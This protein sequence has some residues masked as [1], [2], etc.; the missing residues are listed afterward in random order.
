MS[1]YVLATDPSDAERI[2][3]GLLWDYHGAFTVA[4]LEAAGVGA[5]W[6]CLEVG[7]GGGQLTGWLA[8]RVQPGGRVVAIDLETALLEPLRGEVVEVRRG[9]FMGEAVETAAFDLVLAQM[10]LLHLPDPAAGAR[11]LVEAAKPGGTVVIHDTDFEPVGLRDPTELEREGVAVMAGTMRAAGID[12][13]LGPKLDRVLADAGAEVERFGS[14]PAT[15]A[16]SRTAAE[17]T[18]L[19]LERFGERAIE[20]GTRPEA[21][22]AAIAALRDPQRDFTGPTRWIVRARRR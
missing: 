11:R 14:S 7:A 16:D 13:S 22:E 19:T 8:E 6:S 4:E 10:L 12:L 9:D 15:A 2:R 3:M 21:I 5:G 18:A 17:I 1:D 20:A